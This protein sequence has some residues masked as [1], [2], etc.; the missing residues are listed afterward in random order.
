MRFDTLP[1]KLIECALWCVWKYEDRDGKPTKVP[2]N[3]RTGGRAQSNNPATFSDFKTAVAAFGTCKYDGM[4]IG[5]FPPFAAID[6]DHCVENGILSPLASDIVTHSKSYTEYSPSGK[7]VRIILTVP[8]G[9]KYDKA[10]YYIN[11]QKKGLEVYVSGSTQK[12]VTITG[13][14]ISGDTIQDGESP[15]RFVCEKY[16]ERATQ[17]PKTKPQRKPA[18]HRATMTG[19]YWLDMGMKKDPC[20]SYMIPTCSE[21]SG[22]EL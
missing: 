1:D 9:F 6:I 3:P 2:Y 17:K 18:T 4:G 13:N 22:R 15:L 7:G 5:V 16:M 21:W 8:D 10:R 12:F 19:D 11:N 20:L 14:K